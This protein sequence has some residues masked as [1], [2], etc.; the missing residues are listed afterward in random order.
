MGGSQGSNGES[1]VLQPRQQALLAFSSHLHSKWRCGM[2][3]W[4]GGVITPSGNWWSCS[5]PRGFRGNYASRRVRRWQ[6]G[7]EVASTLHM[8]IPVLQETKALET[9][10]DAREWDDVARTTNLY[11]HSAGSAVLPRRPVWSMLRH[12]F[13]DAEPTRVSTDRELEASGDD[14]QRLELTLA[15]R[16]EHSSQTSDDRMAYKPQRKRSLSGSW[17]LDRELSRC[18]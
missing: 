1:S 17:I 5:A 8:K 10:T 4:C 9:H 12:S 7:S 11:A 16:A 2:I 15:P 3:G 6:V 18:P 14:D 13:H